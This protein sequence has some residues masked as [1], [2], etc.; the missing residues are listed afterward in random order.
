MRGSAAGKKDPLAAIA[1]V[2]VCIVWGSTYLAIR[3]GVS[4]LPPALFAGV[5]F[6]LAGLIMGAFAWLKGMQ[7]PGSWREVAVLSAVGLFLLCGGNGLLVWSEQWISSGLAALL[8]ATN[9]LFTAAIDAVLPGGAPIGPLGW[10]GLLAGFAGVASLVAPGAAAGGFELWAVLGAVL[11]SFFW[12]FGS[13]YSKR[14]PVSGSLVAGISI[15]MLAGGVALTA[16]GLAI[17]EAPRFHLGGQGLGALLYLVFAGSIVGYSAFIYI[18]KAMPV[19]KASTYTY[20]NPVV[21]VIL[22]VLILN[23]QVTLRTLIATA[24]IFMGVLLVQ[25]S[26]EKVASVQAAPERG[27][28][29]APARCGKSTD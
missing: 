16:L 13:V 18:L 21:A 11:G 26:K 28:A 22:G 15:E 7:F 23:E 20:I 19:A 24:V 6:V 14:N 8:V 29:C 3:I 17:G 1:Y 27:L 25:L 9:P 4:D 5:R 12:A 10:L 2:T